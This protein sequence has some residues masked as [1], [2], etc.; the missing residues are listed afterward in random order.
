MGKKNKNNEGE[1]KESREEWEGTVV[2][3]GGFSSVSISFLL[4]HC[5]SIAS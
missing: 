1:G 2:K 4:L 3:L 5:S